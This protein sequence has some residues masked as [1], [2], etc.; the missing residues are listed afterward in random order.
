M[1]DSNENTN[2]S[3]YDVK[4][5]QSDRKKILSNKLRDNL[6]R[7]KS[8]VNTNAAKQSSNANK[9]DKSE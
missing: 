8:K 3:K 5:E 7:R 1:S 2:N 9:L 4:S 6:R